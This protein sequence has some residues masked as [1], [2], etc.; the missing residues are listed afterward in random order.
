MHSPCSSCSGTPMLWKYA[1]QS[2]NPSGGSFGLYPNAVV[3]N[4]I[5]RSAS[6]QSMVNVKLVATSTPPGWSVC[7][8][9]RMDHASCSSSHLRHGTRSMPAFRSVVSVLVRFAVRSF[10][11]NS[12]PALRAAACGGRPRPAGRRYRRG[13]SRDLADG[14]TRWTNVVDQ[15]DGP[16]RWTN[17]MDQHLRPRCGPTRWTNVVDQFNGLA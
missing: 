17:E 3:Q 8:L 4:C 5:I 15:R 14:P 11:T 9:R 13:R 7:L 2:S 12:R 6:P 16:T 10:S 1:H